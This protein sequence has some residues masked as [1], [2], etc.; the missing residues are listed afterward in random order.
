MT[1]INSTASFSAPRKINVSEA[2]IDW[3]LSPLRSRSRVDDAIDH[4]VD[5]AISRPRTARL[6]QHHYRYGDIDIV[7]SIVDGA[8]VSVMMANEAAE[9]RDTLLLTVAPSY[10]ACR[11][12]FGEII[13]RCAHYHRTIA[14][15]R[16]CGKQWDDDSV[17]IISS[18]G[19]V[20]DNVDGVISIA[21]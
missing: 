16:Q 6:D 1:D 13:A 5:D 21:V 9:L 3:L 2:V 12:A 10:T 17:T 19:E 14:S 20:V 15:A 7:V 8:G 11:V 18:R 4:I